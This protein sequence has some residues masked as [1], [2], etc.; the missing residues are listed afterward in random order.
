MGA[1]V[2][3][4]RQ[5]ARAP[6]R[7]P[8]AS[9][10]RQD[11]THHTQQRHHR[12]GRLQPHIAVCKR[13]RL[14]CGGIW[15]GAAGTAGSGCSGP[16]VQYGLAGAEESRAPHNAGG[17][18][19]KHPLLALRCPAAANSCHS[20]RGGMMPGSFA[21]ALMRRH[22]A[23]IAWAPGGGEGE[24]GGT[25]FSP[26]DAKALTQPGWQVPWPGRWGP[27]GAPC[28]SGTAPHS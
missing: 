13:Q 22:T 21:K 20:W 19:A 7:C 11:L 26:Q 3:A 10:A 16:G 1:V 2:G 25:Q 15:W 4:G 27:S 8:H 24:G 17:P 12:N 18:A 14:Q 28:S 6:V 23:V 5:H 9:Q